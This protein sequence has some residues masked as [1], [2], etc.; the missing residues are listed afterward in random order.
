MKSFLRYLWF[1]SNT[2]VFGY[3]LF[4]G[5]M[6]LWFNGYTARVDLLGF[7][8]PHA[9]KLVLWSAVTLLWLRREFGWKFPF[10]TF[11]LYS[12]AELMTNAIYVPVHLFTEEAVYL[13]KVL[14]SPIFA[15]S[16]VF[17]ILMIV[18]CNTFLKREFGFRRHWL[19][20]PF[21]LLIAVW[22]SAGYVTDSTMLY[23]APGIELAEFSWSALYLLMMYH[24]FFRKV[25]L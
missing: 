3:L 5:L 4:D 25:P 9:S 12:M 8:I 6:V 18:L 10:A 22:V 14:E 16:N 19:M 7:L 11:M 13:P 23:A 2:A 1:W 15:L 24:V 21:A 17:F 20:V